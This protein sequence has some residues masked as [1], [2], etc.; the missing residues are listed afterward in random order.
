MRSGR[1]S[2]LVLDAAATLSSRHD[3]EVLFVTRSRQQGDYFV[4]DVK[5][6]FDPK[7]VASDRRDQLRLKN[8]SRLR[9]VA[10]EQ[11]V[12]GNSVNRVLV[13]YDAPYGLALAAIPCEQDTSDVLPYA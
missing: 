10:D 8:G 7:E 1:T 11:A 2:E 9:Y 12:R 3:Q 6:L 4:A 13:D 5:R